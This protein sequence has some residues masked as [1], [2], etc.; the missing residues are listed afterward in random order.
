MLAGLAMERWTPHD[1][2]RTAATILDRAGYSLE[3]IG[4]LLAHT[5]GSV[6][7]SLRS[8]GQVRSSARDGNGRR[9][10]SARDAERLAERSSQDRSLDGT[11]KQHDERAAM[12]PPISFRRRDTL[13]ICPCEREIMCVKRINQNGADVSS[14]CPDQLEQQTAANFYGCAE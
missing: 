5:R 1:L 3:Q 14:L 12:E 7:R 2:Q 9:A 8:M 10:V 6:T 13:A 11:P 4:A